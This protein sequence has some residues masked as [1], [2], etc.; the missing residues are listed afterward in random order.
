MG[1]G[2]EQVVAQVPQTL[3]ILPKIQWIFL[4]KY[5][6]IFCIFLGQFPETLNGLIFQ[7]NNFYLL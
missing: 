6:F 3:T 4:N 5:V 7:K 1:L 2:K